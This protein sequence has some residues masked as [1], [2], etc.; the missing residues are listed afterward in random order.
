M[1]YIEGRSLREKAEAG[2]LELEEAVNLAADIARGLQ[3]AHEKD[4]VHRDIKS[5]NVMVTKKG[6]GK[7]TDFGLAK[8]ADSTRVTKTGT[9]LGTAAYMSPEQARGEDVDQ[10]SDIWSLGVVLY[11]M[12]TGRL[13][14]RGDRHEAVIF[15]IVHEVQEPITAIRGDIPLELERIANK[16]LEK[17]PAN[18]YQYVDELLMDLGQE[19]RPSTARPKRSL[20]KYGI[21]ALVILFAAVMFMIFNPFQSATTPDEKKG[22]VKVAVLPFENL[23]APEDE[24]FADGITDEI[25]S[26]LAVVAGLAVI[27]RTSATKYKNTDKGLREIGKELGVDYVLEGTI[28]WDKRGEHEK[29]RITPQLINVSD[30]FH[31]WAENYEREIEEIFAVQADIA[32][33]IAEALDIALLTSESQSLEARPT[34]SFDAYQAYLRGVD[35]SRQESRVDDKRLGIQMLERAV[36]LDPEFALAYATLS[37]AHSLMYFLGWDRTEARLSRARAAVDTALELQPDLSE[38]HL[39]LAKYHYNGDQDY[40]RALDVLTIVEK[41]LPNDSQILKAR[42][43]ARRGEYEEAVDLLEAAFELSAGSNSLSRWPQTDSGRMGIG[44]TT[45]SAGW[46]IRSGLET[47]SKGCPGKAGPLRCGGLDC[48]RLNA[49]TKPLWILCRRIPSKCP[50]GPLWRRRGLTGLRKNRSLRTPSTIPLAPCSKKNSSK[51]PMVIPSAA[52]S[53][54]P[55]PA[56]AARRKRSVKENGP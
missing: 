44:R 53:V 28:R 31:V 48:G 39:A 43:Q 41:A 51:R 36:E 45:T 25:T 7:I 35:L 10:R 24:Y 54:S 17:E 42:I 1:A 22:S 15:Q 38:A 40:E 37:E 27:S 6:Q 23:G 52:T 19:K 34:E 30:D 50:G 13:P 18:R 55:M 47:H 14:F 8:L 2:P 32:S 56:W 26:K 4:I 49:T 29:V 20:I 11:E 21:P 46:V 12:L 9:S 33:Q 16:C 3:E 5:A